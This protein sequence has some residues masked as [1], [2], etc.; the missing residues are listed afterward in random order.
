VELRG[1]RGS[2][3]AAGAPLAAVVGGQADVGCV[4]EAD[5]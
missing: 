4:G 1:G 5:L 3:A 2:K